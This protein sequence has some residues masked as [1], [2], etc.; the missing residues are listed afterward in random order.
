MTMTMAMLMT[1]P[2][3]TWRKWRVT[4]RQY[5]G[6]FASRTR[7]VSTDAP[8]S[9]RAEAYARAKAPWAW[10]RSPCRIEERQCPSQ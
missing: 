3:P 9:E 1:P 6:W 5:G 10:S 2:R 8:D 7:T 4:F